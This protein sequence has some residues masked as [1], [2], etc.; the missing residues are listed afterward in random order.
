MD[1]DGRAGSL[2]EEGGGVAPED[3]EGLELV[4][5]ELCAL[6]AV[7]ADGEQRR[8]PGDQEAHRDRRRHHDR[9]LRRLL[10]GEGGSREDETEG[11]SEGAHGSG[12]YQRYVP[13]SRMACST[14][15]GTRWDAS[16]PDF[17]SARTWVEDTSGMAT[18][19]SV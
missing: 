6:P 13:A 7:D 1:R 18:R 11:E 9:R 12:R 14:A 5:A 15:R 17:K 3:P 10:V 16:P 19:F 8:L 2:A 4:G